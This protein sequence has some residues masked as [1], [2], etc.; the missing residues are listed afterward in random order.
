MFAARTSLPSAADVDR[1][2]MRAVPA[3]ASGS[4]PAASSTPSSAM[5]APIAS[6]ANARPTALTLAWPSATRTSWSR[7]WSATVRYSA[8]R[9]GSAWQ[10]RSSAA[11]SR[12]VARSASIHARRFSVTVR[13][14][15]A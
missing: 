8:R 4:Q 7:S 1:I 15:V 13:V 11:G 9:Y 3:T 14:I 5:V 2:A 6:P 12:W 10:A